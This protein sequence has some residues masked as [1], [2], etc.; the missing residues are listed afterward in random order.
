MDVVVVGLLA[1][2]LLSKDTK[3]EEVSF[4]A[5]NDRHRTGNYPSGNNAIY[6]MTEE[7]SVG[8]QYER[9]QP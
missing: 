9:H 4:G 2:I 1:G 6:S 7:E 8:A 3:S 5:Q